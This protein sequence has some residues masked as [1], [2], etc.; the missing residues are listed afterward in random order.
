MKRLCRLNISPCK[1][2]LTIEYTF[3]LTT[4]C[5]NTFY[6]KEKYICKEAFYENFGKMKYASINGTAFINISADIRNCKITFFKEFFLY[7]SV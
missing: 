4:L 1:K 5:Q 3:Y 7:L 2:S 6:F